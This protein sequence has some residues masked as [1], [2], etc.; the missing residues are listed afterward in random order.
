MSLPEQSFTDVDELKGLADN[1]G[2]RRRVLLHEHRRFVIAYLRDH[3]RPIA[4]ADIARA[5]ASWEDDSAE[6]LEVLDRAESIF[7]SLHHRHIPK[8]ADAGFVEY[9]RDRKTVALTGNS[10]ENETVARR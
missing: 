1:A 2:A 5:I 4:L 3:D 8:M 9:N 10:N 6:K 7:I